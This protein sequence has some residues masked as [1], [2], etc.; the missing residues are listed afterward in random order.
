MIEEERI[1]C[2]LFAAIQEQVVTPEV[3]DCIAKALT[4]AH[5]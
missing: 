2:R 3:V 4:N 5:A 1:E